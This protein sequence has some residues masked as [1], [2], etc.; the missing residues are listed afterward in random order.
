MAS[1]RSRL[2]L[3]IAM[4]RSVV[5]DVDRVD[6]SARAARHDYDT[7]LEAHRESTGDDSELD[8]ADH[9]RLGRRFDWW[10]PC[11]NAAWQARERDDHDSRGHLLRRRCPWLLSGVRAS[12]CSPAANVVGSWYCGWSRSRSRRRG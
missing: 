2:R 5:R 1:C 10:P 3:P 9:A 7:R 11:W 6:H 8:L 4:A 12:S